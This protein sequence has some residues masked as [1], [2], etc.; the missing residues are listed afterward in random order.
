MRIV[1]YTSPH[2]NPIY[3]F[4]ITCNY[5]YTSKQYDISHCRIL[6]S[7]WFVTVFKMRREHWLQKNTF[8]RSMLWIY[9]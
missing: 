6:T 5:H 2:K 8:G 7:I 4:P 9:I 1:Q 3:T